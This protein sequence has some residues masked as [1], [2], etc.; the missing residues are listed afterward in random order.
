LLLAVTTLSQCTV[1]G[2]RFSV[3]LEVT[4]GCWV[5]EGDITSETVLA[6]SMV[7]RK[8]PLL[9]LQLLV[10]SLSVGRCLPGEPYLDMA[11]GP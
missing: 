1:S 9:R 5:D 4:G 8:F 6:M 11:R 7:V 2:H 10:V 3:L